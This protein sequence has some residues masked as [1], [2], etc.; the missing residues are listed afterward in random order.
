MKDGLHGSNST[1]DHFSSHYEEYVEDA[2]KVWVGGD[3]SEYFLRL[4]ADEMV[5]H[6]RRLGLDP[7][8]LTALDVGCGT[9]VTARML[10]L[11]FAALHG[12]DSSR[13]M[14]ERARQLSLPDVSFQ[15]SDGG[16]LPFEK[17][18]FDVVYSMSLFHHVPPEYRLRTLAEMVRVLKPGGW[19]FNFEHNPLNPLTRLIVRRCPLDQG[20]ELLHAREMTRLC[21]ESNLGQIHMRF[22]LFFPKQVKFMRSFESYLSWLPLGGQF[23][24]CGR[25]LN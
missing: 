18:R 16:R 1:F 10:Y 11:K 23:Y 19:V 24:V 14:I 12:V 4:K 20:V 13:G 22:I 17:N 9:G 3:S 2:L 5:L 15:I 7:M 25:K 21:R 8:K 6:L